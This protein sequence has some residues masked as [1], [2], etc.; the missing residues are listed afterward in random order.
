M[1]WDQENT[2][3]S[4][5]DFSSKEKWISLDNEIWKRPKQILRNTPYN[6]I[7][8]PHYYI[9]YPLQWMSLNSTYIHVKTFLNSDTVMALWHQYD[10]FPIRKLTLAADFQS[11]QYRIASNPE[12]QSCT[13]TFKIHV[14]FCFWNRSYSKIEKIN[15]P[16]FVV[17]LIEISSS[18]V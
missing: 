9:W 6:W 3:I 17:G 13:L 11:C 16:C 5:F 7:P 1:N 15:L 14:S 18:Y 4:C 8:K 10:R 2:V 12:R